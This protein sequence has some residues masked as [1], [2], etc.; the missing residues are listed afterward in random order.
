VIS[1]F[2]RD[3]LWLATLGEEARMTVAVRTDHDAAALRTLAKVAVTPEQTRRRLAIALVREGS[4]RAVAARSTGMDRQ[5]LRDWVHRYN[6][7]GPEGLGDR[8]AP[9][10]SRRLDAAQLA[11]LKARVAAGPDPARDG[12]VRW[13]LADLCGWAEARFQVGYQE[14]GMGKI[15]RSLGCSRSSA[16]PAHPQAD[17]ERQAELKKTAR[18]ERGG[19]G[20]EGPRQAARDLVP[21]RGPNRPEGRAD[22][23]LGR[24]RAPAARQTEHRRCRCWAKRGSRPRQPRDQRYQAAYLFGAVCPSRGATAALVLPAVNTEAMSLQLAEIGRYVAADGHAVVILD[25]AGWHGAHARRSPDNISLLPLPPYS[26][27]LN[28]IGNLWQFLKHNFLNTRVFPTYQDLLDACCD[29]GNRLRQRPD[30]IR[31]IT[32]RA[33]AKQVTN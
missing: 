17:P 19:H 7:K 24:A 27:E 1:P 12:V 14:R 33:W 15:L 10:R 20:R 29:A 21:G 23:V 5:T 25:Q 9:G 18:A 30:Q 22:P 8:K 13:R 16:R 2:C 26:P 28:P 4:S 31:S 3:V 11:E 32:T 6:A